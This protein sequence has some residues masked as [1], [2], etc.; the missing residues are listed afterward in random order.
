MSTECGI[1]ELNSSKDDQNAANEVPSCYQENDQNKD[2]LSNPN[3]SSLP[4]DVSEVEDSDI[5][6]DLTGDEAS[7]DDEED[8]C[9]YGDEDVESQ[10]LCDPDMIDEETQQHL[11]ELL[12][13]AGVDDETD[14]KD[15]KVIKCLTD[16]MNFALDEATASLNSNPRNESSPGSPPQESL[17][18]KSLFRRILTKQLK[19]E[20]AHKTKYMK[21]LLNAL[22]DSDNFLSVACATGYTNLVKELLE[23]GK[24]KMKSPVALFEAA[25][26]G[27]ADC[28]QLLLKHGADVN[29][30]SSSNTS[31]SN[32]S[33]VNGNTALH[34]AACAGHVDVV[35][36]LVEAGANVEEQNENGHTPLMEAASAGHVPVSKLLLDYGAGINTHSNEF[37]ESALTLACY[38]GHLEMVKF[39]LS[40]GADQEHKTDEMHT[41]LMEASMDGH[42]EVA[43]LLLDSGAQ[44]NM[45]AESFESPLTLAACGGHTDLAM[46]LIERGANLEE[47]NDEG[48]TPLMEAAREGH[49]EMVALLLSYGAKINAQTEETQ[50][51]ALTLS[52]CGGFL[53]V[54]NFLITAGAD[55]ELGCST[56][57]MEA[58]QEGHL[59]LVEFLLNAS[60]NVHHE[61]STG[62]TALTYACENGH[63]AVAQLLVSRNAKLEHESEGG[64]TPLMKAARSGHLSTV[65]FLVKE[66]A[67]VNRSTSNNDHTVLSLACAGG[68]VDVVQFL[69]SHGADPHHKL[70]DGST[71]L[72]EAAKGGHTSIVNILLDCPSPPTNNVDVLN[73]SSRVP[74]QGL[75]N[76]VPA[77]T[78]QDTSPSAD[79]TPKAAVV[80]NVLRAQRK[81]P[82]P[83]PSTPVPDFDLQAAMKAAVTNYPNGENPQM[84][85]EDLLSNLIKTIELNET[86]AER[87]KALS[88]LL[89]SQ[90]PSDSNIQCLVRQLQNLTDSLK[91]EDEYKIIQENCDQAEIEKILRKDD[92]VR[93]LP[94][95]LIESQAECAQEHQRAM[96]EFVERMKD[97]ENRELLEKW[98][99]QN[100]QAPVITPLPSDLTKPDSEIFKHPHAQQQLIQQSMLLQQ[101]LQTARHHQ[102]LVRQQVDSTDHVTQ[103]DD[104]HSQIEALE[105]R[106]KYINRLMQLTMQHQN[107]QSSPTNTNMAS[108]ST[109]T[110]L[111]TSAKKQHI[112]GVPPTC[113]DLP[114]AK[115]QKKK[116]AQIIE[117]EPSEEPVPAI[118]APAS[119]TSQSVTPKIDVDAQTESN[120]DTAL[121]LACAGGHSELVKLLLQRGANI[122]HKDKKGFTPLILAATAGHAE[123]VDILNNH[124]ADMEA[125]S[126]RTKDTP[127][128]LA[129]SG[130]RMEVVEYLLSKGANKE[131]RN[132]SDYTPLSLAAS[133][134]YVNIIRLLLSHGAE[135]NSRT[136]SKLGIS[137][138]MLAAMNGHTAAVKL[139]LE[140]GSDI[141]AQIETNRNTALTLACFQGRHEVVKLLVERKA[142]IEHRAKTG[143]T[144]L[145]EAASGGYVEVGQVLLDH[146]ADV[147]ASPVPSSRDTALT[148]A[149][150]K[151][152]CRFVELLLDRS[153]TIE[154]KNKKG[155]S[156]LWLA[157]HGGHL[158]VVQLLVNRY[159]DVDSRDNRKVS[160]LMAAFRNGHVKVVKWLVK[161]VQQF[162]L[163]QECERFIATQNPATPQEEEKLKKCRQCMEIIIAAKER[164]AQE[165]NKNA[166]M[167][168]E[169]LDLEKKH[170]AN[171]KETAKRKREKRKAKKKGKSDKDT[172]DAKDDEEKFV[173]ISSPEPPRKIV[174]NGRAISLVLVEQIPEATTVSTVGPIKTTTTPLHNNTSKMNGSIENG[175]VPITP[176]PS[177]RRANNIRSK[178]A[179]HVTCESAVTS[180]V[181]SLLTVSSPLVQLLSSSSNLAASTA[182]TYT[183]TRKPLKTPEKMSI[184]SPKRSVKR[185]EGWKE[186]TRK[187]QSTRAKKVKVASSCIS[188]VIGRGGCNI[189]AI[190][191]LSGAH[192][193]VEKQKAGCVDRMIT[194][195]GSAENIRDAQHLIEQL[196]HDPSKDLE[197]LSA[198]K[199][200]VPIVE[201]PSSILNGTPTSVSGTPTSNPLTST[202]NSLPKSASSKTKTPKTPKSI[203]SA[204]AWNL[205]EMMTT[206]SVTPI[207][208]YQATPSS[209]VA[210]T[211]SPITTSS[212]WCT[213][214]PTTSMHFSPF[215][216]RLSNV[217]EILEKK[218][219]EDDHEQR[220]KFAEVAAEG[221][222]QVQVHPQS[223][224]ENAFLGSGTYSPIV[225][226]PPATTAYGSGI[227]TSRFVNPD[228]GTAWNNVREPIFVETGRMTMGETAVT[229]IYFKN[230]GYYI[231]FYALI[232]YFL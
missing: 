69:L 145:M 132:V 31:P 195:K 101:Q 1:A 72:I 28:V 8:E 13:A 75:R 81:H 200:K 21:H 193:E 77:P 212:T 198:Q 178:R 63:T 181:S 222:P 149:A 100:E 185:D 42:V 58:S 224:Y 155:N 38:K 124:G 231:I 135:I 165:A 40:A 156:P 169:Q 90:D 123:V 74:V 121:T 176:S 107:L 129:C 226:P 44:V 4:S 61:T 19:S 130:G 105:D 116:H 64:R 199:I 48:Y 24:V 65:E 180:V 143:L 15:E 93:I 173:K 157:C 86:H 190:R 50:E 114:H 126:E 67:D 34:Y 191:E 232:A 161:H 210:P 136:G 112:H 189:N 154:V 99:Q 16:T 221:L 225:V 18:V 182:V 223:T 177:S 219:C 109:Q 57:L 84:D 71:M 175:A 140:M 168:L 204:P 207:P 119:T 147:N 134:G 3:T 152:H 158:D 187:P 83:P 137:P 206:D 138:L 110:V 17:D 184:A 27:H 117:P 196:I 43:K 79:Q 186:V 2:T 167:L 174:E 146:G 98:L 133:G 22:N 11:T 10:F 218:P 37:K 54:A 85:V 111:P 201:L 70:K 59:Q 23:V 118:V 170:E 203:S 46:V 160:C 192:I 51:T 82:P 6:E 32:G 39:L 104:V 88:D 139:L 188:R 52:C 95:D 216:H 142:N 211:S 150:D 108:S 122:E 55:L 159:A 30:Q 220:K 29:A 35:K 96:K 12:N 197:H 162:P 131:H 41:A 5:D 14:F 151:G 73:D 7:D 68:H 25:V 113:S 228:F 66:G 115:K 230:Q 164:Q 87:K 62:D 120:H 217:S 209:G 141:N 127:L 20:G 56:P 80:R 227:T 163:D 229:G 94:P 213:P 47:V 53:N 128:S 208:S 76:I 92:G 45:P 194:I 144:P 97:N 166:V 179:K 153:A 183:T 148:I 214:P 36:V 33:S 106:L 9:Y 102:A 91:M 205:G 26:H 171:K 125:Q 103:L 202:S 215:Q 60:A 49:E 172:P 78:P 89:K